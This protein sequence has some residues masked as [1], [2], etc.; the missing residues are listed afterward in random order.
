LIHRI[1]WRFSVTTFASLRLPV[2]TCQSSLA[3]LLKKNGGLALLY[4]SI[5]CKWRIHSDRAQ[6]AGSEAL[7]PAASVIEILLT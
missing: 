5:S 2:S 1:N 7:P 4:A 6:N 3:H